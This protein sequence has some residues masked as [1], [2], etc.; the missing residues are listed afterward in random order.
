MPDF[1]FQWWCWRVGGLPQVSR[2]EASLAHCSPMPFEAVCRPA[3]NRRAQAIVFM[4]RP[5]KGPQLLSPHGLIPHHD[6]EHPADPSSDVAATLPF[7]I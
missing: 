5:R 3:H 6:P 1:P 7:L 2:D 4:Q